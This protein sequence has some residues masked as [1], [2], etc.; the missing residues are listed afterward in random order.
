MGYG[1]GR[2]WGVGRR[3]RAG[4]GISGD[5]ADEEGGGDMA[6]GSGMGGVWGGWG[7]GGGG[8]GG[9]E[10]LQTRIARA[11]REQAGGCVSLIESSRERRRQKSAIDLAARAA[12]ANI[13]AYSEY[14]YT[15]GSARGPHDKLAKT[16][17]RRKVPDIYISYRGAPG[18]CPI[19]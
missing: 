12:S 8:E 7:V 15:T 14:Y 19:Y 4:A 6:Y 9:E 1:V 11:R 10:A 3:E 16:R 2:G 13:A 5:G 18:G 17:S